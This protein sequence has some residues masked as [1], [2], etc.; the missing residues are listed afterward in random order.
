MSHSTAF[1]RRFGAWLAGLSLFVSPSHP[2]TTAEP[3]KR[4]VTVRDA[5][6]MTRWADR[7]YFLGGPAGDRV[8]LFA[9]DGERFLVVVEKGN[10]ERNTRQSSLLLFRT[11][12]VFDSPGPETLL[13]ME[14]SSNREAISEVR[15]LS[16][17]QT[18]LFLGE[19]PG[20]T[21]AVYRFDL[22][23]KRLEKLT[24]HPSP[25]LAF[26]TSRDG[27]E[28]LYLAAASER[29]DAEAGERVIT[30]QNP[31]NLFTCNDDLYE[32]F[33]VANR[34][35]FLKRAG[36][37]SRR[38]AAT[39]FFSEYLPL[40][41]S[42]SG[43]YGLVSAFVSDIP[44]SWSQYQ[45]PVLHPYIVD[46][47]K[48]GARSNVRR[49]LVLD[50]QTLSFGPLIDAPAYWTNTGF[51]WAPDE[52]SVAVSGTYLPL[53]TANA[54]E[55]AA[56]EKK[57][58]AVEVS[59][60]GR[61]LRKITDKDLKIQKWDTETGK[62]IFGSGQRWKKVPPAA[63]ATS[64]GEWTEVPVV[65]ED[66][67]S[68]NPLDVALEE[69]IETPP[70]IFVSQ[71]RTRRRALLLDLNPQFRELEFGHVEAVSW[72]ATD[73]HE[74]E[75]GLYLPPDYKAGQRYPLVIQTHGFRRD[76]FWID[77][78]WSSAFAA[79]PLAAAG[80]AVLQIGGSLDLGEDLKAANSPDEAPRQ[81]AA[82]EGAIDSLNA[83]GLI[84]R[85]RV[86]VIGFSRTV[87]YVEYTLT[88]SRY[89]F[90]AA[91]LADGFDGGYLN[92]LLWPDASYP[93]VNGGAPFGPSFASWVKNSPGFN[94]DRITAPVHLEY[95]GPGAV[96]GGWQW[97]SGLSLLGKPVEF[98][99]LPHGTHLL[100]RPSDRLASQERNVDW[101]RFWLKDERD[102]DPAKAALYKGW[103][104]LRSLLRER[105]EQDRGA[106]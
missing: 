11:D 7:G 71:P 74:V 3:A 31:S 1:A 8:G 102:P 45:D 96:L 73:G 25:I 87:F 20:E 19:N 78:P 70:K 100:V 10:V 34:E 40:S 95:Y 62:V 65:E 80:I 58:F 85:S 18:I 28:I 37:A 4:R 15:W 21:S 50:T 5:I 43:R 39:D 81:M 84:D 104:D 26:D 9:P 64:G 14:S 86:G 13:T 23:T 75:G 57:A 35:L 54:T 47:R 30:T 53:D 16:D 24:D 66:V 69:D 46:R 55:E 79:Q 106:R 68:Q 6:E 38:I 97:F 33:E 67:R 98:I 101:F 103:D 88:H 82:Y 36:E 89:P 83:R 91:S 48:P 90:H 32:K 44:S 42:P 59:F 22:R 12:K 60:A 2:A 77:G 52:K 49:Y 56:R 27:R 17:S 76:R 63:Y 61:E 72:K 94:L 93:L 51:A 105:E 99:W 29:F 92:Y 41:L